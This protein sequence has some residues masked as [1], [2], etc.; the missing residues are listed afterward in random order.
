M[1]IDTN[2][3]LKVSSYA[4]RKKKCV[5]HI[6]KLIKRKKIDSVIIDGLIFVVNK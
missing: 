4:T 1:I 5:Q 2:K 6:Y 3:L